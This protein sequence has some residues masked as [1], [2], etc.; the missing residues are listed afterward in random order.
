MS[1]PNDL[2]VPELSGERA[3]VTGGAGFIGSHICR[4]LLEAGASVCVIDDLSTGRRERVPGGVEFIEASVLDAYALKRAVEGCSVVFHKAAMVSVVQS[5]EEPQRCMDVNVQG[6]L[7]VLEAAR[8]AG[9]RRVVLA[10]SAAVYGGEPSLPSV[11]SD[12]IDCWSPY[13]MSKAASEQ[14]C[15]SYSMCYGL[16]TASLRYFNVYGPGQDAKSAYAAV[17]SAFAD[18]LSKG[19]A[20]VIHGDGGQT[21]DFVFVEDVA[22]ANL[23][24]GWSERELKGEAINIGTGRSVSLLELLDEM[25][26][27]AGSDLEPE[28]GP[29]R[30]GDV[31]HSKAAAERAESLIGFR[32]GASLADGLERTMAWMRGK[33]GV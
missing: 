15:R 17:I 28:F 18:R 22:R 16:S 12:A 11:E 31:R 25:K 10:S 32:A 24:A 29:A 14:L 8:G 21:R 33:A 4:A 19:T 27:I 26:R 30:A 20:P 3:L 5:V 1:E 23:L 2:G 13:A 9:V 7:R 6:T